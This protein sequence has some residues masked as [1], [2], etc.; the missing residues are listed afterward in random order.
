MVPQHY[1]TEHCIVYSYDLRK[2]AD[3]HR[4]WRDYNSTRTGAAD[5]NTFE[6]VGPGLSWAEMHAITHETSAT[7]GTYLSYDGE[8][9]TV[10][11][12]AEIIGR[13]IAKMGPALW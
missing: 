9:P 10:F 8:H 6:P 4:G 13:V 12:Q 1:S 7:A 2:A 5:K 3:V 11:A